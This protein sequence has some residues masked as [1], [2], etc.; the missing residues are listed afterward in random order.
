MW[1]TNRSLTNRSLTTMLTHDIVLII[2]LPR[3]S[4]DDRANLTSSDATI[5]CPRL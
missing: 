3:L 4:N 1:V 5:V 2:E